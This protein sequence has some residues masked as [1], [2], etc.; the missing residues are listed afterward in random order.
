MTGDV[1]QSRGTNN[2][3]LDRRNMKDW[4]GSA[5][6]G[7]KG[8]RCLRGDNRPVGFQSEGEGVDEV[9]G[10]LEMRSERQGVLGADQR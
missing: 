7:I 9:R 5:V 10:V 4:L 2:Y 3:V 6:R 8:G 1:V